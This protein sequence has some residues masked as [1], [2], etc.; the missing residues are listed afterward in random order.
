MQTQK[1]AKFF[2]PVEGQE[3]ED[4]VE[5]IVLHE[6]KI[7]DGV[8]R[9]RACKKAKVEPRFE[10]YEGNGDL[11]E[12][13]VSRNVRRRHL[14]ESQRSILALE[15]LPALTRQVDTGRRKAISDARRAARG[16]TPRDDGRRASALA[17]KAVGVRRRTVERAKRIQKEAPDQIPLIREGKK[18]VYAVEEEIIARKAAARVERGEKKRAEQ[19]RKEEPRIVAAYLDA[20]K[21]FIRSSTDT[22]EILRPGDASPEAVR[23]IKRKHE[24]VRRLIADVEGVLD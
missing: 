5:E 6:G 23:F 8:N 4:L 1:Y 22:S 19:K 14:S 20:L 7:L 9:Y 12:Y 21:Q 18:S 17:A 11:F 2:P 10:E 16:P 13:V 3:F 15:M 24:K